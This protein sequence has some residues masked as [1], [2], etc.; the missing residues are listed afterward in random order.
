MNFRSGI[1]KPGPVAPGRIEASKE[2]AD[3]ALVTPTTAAKELSA[4]SVALAQK[5]GNPEKIGGAS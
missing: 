4:V 1:A 5:T 3:G 2:K